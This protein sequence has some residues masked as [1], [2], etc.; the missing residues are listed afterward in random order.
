MH[1]IGCRARNHAAAV[2]HRQ[3]SGGPLSGLNTRGGS[4]RGEGS[5]ASVSRRSGGAAGDWLC[6]ANSMQSMWAGMR[7]LQFQGWCLDLP[8]TALTLTGPE[9]R[10]PVASAEQTEQ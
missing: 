6:F 5:L 10:L 9:G 8:S 2:A 4:W 7:E 3:G 1:A